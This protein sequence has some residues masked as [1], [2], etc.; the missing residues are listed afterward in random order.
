MSLDKASGLVFLG[1]HFSYTL[2]SRAPHMRDI[3]NNNKKESACTHTL[4]AH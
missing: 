1:F 3:L 2:K 4:F